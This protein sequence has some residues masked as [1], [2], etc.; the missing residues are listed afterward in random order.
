MTKIK[1]LFVIII[2]FFCSCKKDFTL[3]MPTETIIYAD[4]VNSPSDAIYAYLS[5]NYATKSKRK[6][7]EYQEFTNDKICSFNQSFR[8][9][10]N[11]SL[12]NCDIA[13]GTKIRIEMPKVPKDEIL[14]W[15]ESIN[16]MYMYANKGSWN[17]DKMEFTP[18]NEV[19]SC[20]LKINDNIDF[21]EILILCSS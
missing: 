16:S 4:E 17:R 12:N 3:I 11:F 18:T 20:Y 6:E 10:I 9:S 8:N 5:K 21:W 14:N 1:L 13:E 7:I 15:L 2:V 19:S